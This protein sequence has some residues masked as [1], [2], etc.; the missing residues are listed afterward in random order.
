MQRCGML[1]A[2]C[3]RFVETFR[4]SEKYVLLLP[5]AERQRQ[6]RKRKARDIRDIIP[7]RVGMVTEEFARC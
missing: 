7:I 1:C 3:K 2:S 5:K 4:N 6:V